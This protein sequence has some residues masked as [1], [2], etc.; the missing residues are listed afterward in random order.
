MEQGQEVNTATNRGTAM[1]RVLECY[2]FTRTLASVEKQLRE[3]EEQQ[4]IDKKM[5]KMINV[6]AL[7]RF[8]NTSLGKRMQKAAERGKLYR[9]KPFV[10][11]KP[12]S[13]ALAESKSQEML[14][15]QGIIDVF[16][17]EEDGIVLMDYKTDRVKTAEE[18]SERY[19][20][21]MEL[22]QEAIERA[23][24][25]PVKERIIYSF[26]LNEIVIV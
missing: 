11:G 21:Q 5:R 13:E 6:S 10:M 19:R 12:A 2:D 22:Y 9:E 4:K 20:K 8:L 25:S 26:C 17:E 15:I 16:F 14:L 23:L 3:M 18:L 1:H 7:K 24:G